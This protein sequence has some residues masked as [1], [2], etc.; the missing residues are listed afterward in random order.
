MRIS[1]CCFNVTDSP[2]AC[3]RLT[4]FCNLECSHCFAEAGRSAEKAPL[5]LDSLL[6]V[7]DA[8]KCR[9]VTSIIFSG[10]EPLLHTSLLPLVAAAESAGIRTSI[11]TNAMA[12]TGAL[13]AKLKDSGLSYA[14]VS[15]DGPNARVYGSVRSAPTAFTKVLQGIKALVASDMHVSTN[16][17][18]HLANLDSIRDIVRLAA[19]LGIARSAFTIPVGSRSKSLDVINI[20]KATPIILETLQNVKKELNIPMELELHDPDC[21]NSSCP[22]GKNILGVKENGEIISCLVKEWV[23]APSA[24]AF[25]EVQ[26]FSFVKIAAS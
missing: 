24:M 23:E 9:R 7:L 20:R 17:V 25:V 1:S 18:L 10:G 4:R 13:C 26:P 11:V 6:R 21:L 2:K 8:L 3:W 22:A 5:N 16:T 14:T 19:Q 12:A 15:L